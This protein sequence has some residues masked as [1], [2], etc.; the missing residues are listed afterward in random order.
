M[1]GEKRPLDD[2][3]ELYD[4]LEIVRDRMAALAVTDAESAA[5][6]RQ[7]LSDTVMVAE[8]GI[9][10][11]DQAYI[12]QELGDDEPRVDVFSEDAY[13]VIRRFCYARRNVLFTM[14][15]LR[16][17]LEKNGVDTAD[18]TYEELL[19]YF[20]SLIPSIQADLKTFHG[21]NYS[22]LEDGDHRTFCEIIPASQQQPVEAEAP[23]SSN[24]FV[25]EPALLPEGAST[26]PKPKPFRTY[27]PVRSERI[28]DKLD[29]VYKT[30]LE[31][32]TRRG[33]TVAR[34]EF[35]GLLTVRYGLNDEQVQDFML[36]FV[37]NGMLYKYREGG[38]SWITTNEG[39]AIEKRET[40]RAAHRR[41]SERGERA[42]EPV[43]I[44]HAHDVLSVF[45]APNMHV[46]QLLTA[47][48]VWLGMQSDK[49]NE[50]AF[51]AEER[52][53][54]NRTVNR[55]VEAGLMT[56]GQRGHRRGSN[57]RSKDQM[58]QKMG[59][60]SQAVKEELMQLA[61]DKNLGE[62]LVTLFN[63]G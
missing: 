60:Y 22:W 44:S 62:W 19:A 54:I 61:A 42:A 31:Y 2:I 27:V 23:V 15:T 24:D 18:V 36:Q 57:S 46:Q 28:A 33:G 7:V 9:A 63:Q 41:G 55:L 40:Y 10:D 17:H 49:V 58:V 30:C 6:Y 45:L 50:V 32:L 56:K 59:L 8:Q 35:T 3:H 26:I 48:E 14:D 52:S 4:A 37:E 39:L 51:S 1:T 38:E 53:R 25:N 13:H 16:A 12:R 11:V 47:K 34:K 20:D 5:A 43:D 21:Q 29:E